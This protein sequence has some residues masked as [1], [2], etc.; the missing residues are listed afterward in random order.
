MLTAVG[1]LRAEGIRVYAAALTGG[2]IPL[3]SGLL[4][5]GTAVLIGN[6]GAGLPAG[7]IACCNGALLIE[8]PGGAESLGAAAAATI[9]LWEMRGRQ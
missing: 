1:A 8:M 2:A 5:G 4:G 7:L 3:R 6:E 9:F